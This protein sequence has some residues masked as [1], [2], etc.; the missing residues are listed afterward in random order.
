MV[1]GLMPALP[2]GR[3]GLLTIKQLIKSH[4]KDLGNRK[5]KISAHA[6]S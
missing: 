1:T 4:A 6:L 5:I 2:A 3:V